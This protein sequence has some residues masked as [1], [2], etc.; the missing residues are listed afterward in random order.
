[1][2]N[3]LY[4]FILGNIKRQMEIYNE[5]NIK[6]N[7]SDIVRGITSVIWINIFFSFS[8]LNTNKQRIIKKQIN[9]NIYIYIFY[10]QHLIYM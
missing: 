4:L 1:M 9:K 6:I 3:N 7:T 10:I 8:F 2:F 5:V